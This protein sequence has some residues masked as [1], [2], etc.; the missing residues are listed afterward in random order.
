MIYFSEV[1]MP[2]DITLDEVAQFLQT[3]KE[4]GVRPQFDVDMLL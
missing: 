3:F 1:R 4:N 2:Q